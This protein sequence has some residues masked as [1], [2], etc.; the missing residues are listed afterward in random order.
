MVINPI[1]DAPII[2]IY[3]GFQ[4]EQA[5]GHFLLTIRLPAEIIYQGYMPVKRDNSVRDRK[6]KSAEMQQKFPSR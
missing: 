5:C 3:Y 4:C 1:L 6:I 2:R